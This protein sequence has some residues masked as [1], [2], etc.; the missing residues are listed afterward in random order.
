[1]NLAEWQQALQDSILSGK[2]YL[3]DSIHGNSAER[4]Q[5][6]DIYQQAYV[7]RLNEALETNYPAI[8]Q[9]LGDDDFFTMAVTY[10]KKHPS[11]HTS[12]RW[13]G[14][15]LS[16]FLKTVIPYSKLPVLSEIAQFE[17]AMR[18]T[19][20]AA[21]SNRITIDYLSD[22]HPDDWP[23]L[24]L[25]CHPSMTLLSFN[26]NAVQI[27]QAIDQCI[28]VPN[29]E[30]HPSSWVIYRDKDYLTSWRSLEANEAL[31]LKSLTEN[32]TFA[33]LC[34][35]VAS[36]SSHDEEGLSCVAG[37]LKAWIEAGL[38]I[39]PTNDSSASKKA[40]EYSASTISNRAL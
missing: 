12:I 25:F 14:A 31:A 13:Y 4:E 9:I 21:D 34:E 26:W 37:F 28:E 35:R 11:E 2:N 39:H 29:P 18:H 19:I 32:L 36:Q 3:S 40:C 6:L 16:D 23:S 27:W 17:W 38:L 1:M 10:S 24:R 15:Y 20:D 5:R 7:L 22:H 30:S 33:D 8:Y